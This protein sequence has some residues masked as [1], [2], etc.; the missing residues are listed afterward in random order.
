LRLARF[1]AVKN[2]ASVRVRILTPSSY[3]LEE[4]TGSGWGV[5]RPTIDFDERYWT[6]G[7]SLSSITDPA[8]FLSSGRVENA[9]TFFVSTEGQETNLVTVSLSGMVRQE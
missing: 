9:V 3:L 6:R 5:L 8:V 4:D 1:E 2:N 7:V